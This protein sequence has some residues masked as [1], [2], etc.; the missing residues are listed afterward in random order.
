MNKSAGLYWFY[1]KKNE[2]MCNLYHFTDLIITNEK[3]KGG[4]SLASK[5]SQIHTSSEI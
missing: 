3:E 1:R 4:V 2:T 5:I